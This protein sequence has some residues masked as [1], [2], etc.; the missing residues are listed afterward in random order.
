MFVLFVSDGNGSIGDVCISEMS[1]VEY[2]KF[3]YCDSNKQKFRACIC[4]K[5]DGITVSL[6]ILPMRRCPYGVFVDNNTR[7]CYQHI[8]EREHIKMSRA[9]K[10]KVLC[11]A[12]NLTIINIKRI[13]KKQ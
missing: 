9:V 8:A 6:L 10:S 7:P 1:I 13:S 11:V 4:R 2:Y 3:W 5:V 12:D